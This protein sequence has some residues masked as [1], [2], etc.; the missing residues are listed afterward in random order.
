MYK[1]CGIE[2][3][4]AE[5]DTLLRGLIN[6]HNCIRHKSFEGPCIR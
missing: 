3:S 4:A 2:G 5:V 6:N 1:L